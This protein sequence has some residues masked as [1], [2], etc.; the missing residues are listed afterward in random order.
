M[1]G[2]PRKSGGLL[3]AFQHTVI[4]GSGR[5]CVAGLVGWSTRRKSIA[6]WNWKGGWWV[7][8][9]R[10]PGRE[11]EGDGAWP[12][13]AT[14]AGLWTWPISTVVLM[15]GPTSAPSSIATTASVWATNSLC[16]VGP[17]KQNALWKP[18]VLRDLVPYIHHRRKRHNY[19]AITG[20]SSSQSVFAK[21]AELIVWNS[22]SSPHTHH[23]RTAWLNGSFGRSKR[24]AFGCRLSVLFEK[25]DIRWRSGFAGTTTAAPIRR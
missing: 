1:K 3:S 23:S 13:T 16:A 8:A 14:S 6:W 24:S 7:N 10:R 22:S 19:A 18:L 2:W 9:R 20:L 4:G 12:S 17:R 11:S 21:P 15:A 5:F 25:P